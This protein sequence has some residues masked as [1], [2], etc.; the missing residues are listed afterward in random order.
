MPHQPL[1]A[2]DTAAAGSGEAAGRVRVLQG[3]SDL[4]AADQ[5]WGAAAEAVNQQLLEIDPERTVAMTRLARCLLNKGEISAAEELYARVITLEPGNMIA[6]NF[7]RRVG[8]ARE[9]LLAEERLAAR[10]ARKRAPAK[11][12]AAK[13]DPAESGA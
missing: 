5:E 12:G 10:A 7:L 6:K 4:F 9:Q 2:G 3:Q 11:R 13:A 8:Q 1:D